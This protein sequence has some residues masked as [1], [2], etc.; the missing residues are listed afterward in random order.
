MADVAL[1]VQGLDEFRRELRRLTGMGKE[2]GRA[3]RRVAEMVASGARSKA[4]SLGG[5]Q[6]KSAPSIRA[7]GAQA[8]SQVALGG[9]RYP[10]ALGAEFGSIRYKQFP[11]W[12]GSAQGAGYFLF[13]TIRESRDAI[14]DA[15]GEELDR[16]ARRAFPS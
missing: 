12:R 4:E 9:A 7:L 3:N 16:L 8:R 6:A 5:V 1:K 13:P 10:F 11:A 14:V 15:Y 2:L